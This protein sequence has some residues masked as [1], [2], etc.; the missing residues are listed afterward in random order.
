MLNKC[1]S[2]LSTSPKICSVTRP[3][4]VVLSMVLLDSYIPILQDGYTHQTD[5]S[6]SYLCRLP[7]LD[8]GTG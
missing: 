8:P 1:R 3:D 4:R 7:V 2:A 6:N 5:K